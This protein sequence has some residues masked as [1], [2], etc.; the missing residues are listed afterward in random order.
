M[1]ESLAVT[2]LFADE[3]LPQEL[4]GL[5]HVGDVVER[6]EAL[7]FVLALFLKTAKERETFRL[8]EQFHFFFG[9]LR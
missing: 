4:P 8:R 1:T 9:V 6:T 7:V 5:E 3:L 2:H